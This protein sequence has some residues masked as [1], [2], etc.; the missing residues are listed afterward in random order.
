MITGALG[1]GDRSPEVRTLASMCACAGEIFHGLFG[2]VW[3]QVA[4]C[5][6]GLSLPLERPALAYSHEHQA[7]PHFSASPPGWPSH[8]CSCVG[9]GEERKRRACSRHRCRRECSQQRLSGSPLTAERRGS[10]SPP[11][12]SLQ[13]TLTAQSSYI[14]S[15][16]RLWENR[17]SSEQGAQAGS[18]GQAHRP[19]RGLTQRDRI[20]FEAKHPNTRY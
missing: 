15:R 1:T 17:T 5:S 19:H 14:N 9:G 3:P 8:H 7:W 2:S 18:L 20:P 10:P 12:T 4:I 6:G 11:C 13:Q 16:G